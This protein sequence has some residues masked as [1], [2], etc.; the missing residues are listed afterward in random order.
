VKADGQKQEFQ[1]V[2]NEPEAVLVMTRF[3]EEEATILQQ[4]DLEHEA[5]L[6]SYLQDVFQWGEKKV[7]PRYRI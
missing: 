6:D 7:F 2:F 5:Q 1:F 3:T 4:F